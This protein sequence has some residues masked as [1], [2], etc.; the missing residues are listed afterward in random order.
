MQ[1]PGNFNWDA[2]LY[3]FTTITERVR[4]QIRMEAFDSLNHANLSSLQTNVSNSQLG[5]STGRTDSRV[6]E[7]GGRLSF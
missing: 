4:L 5:V 6:V 1:S 7:F 2:A 3:K